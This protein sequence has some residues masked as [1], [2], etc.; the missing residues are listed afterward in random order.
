MWTS[1]PTPVTTSSI[2]LLKRIDRQADRH[3]EEPAADRAT[4]NSIGPTSGRAKDRAQRSNEAD[5]TP[6]PTETNAL[7]AA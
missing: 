6:T 1:A 2:I 4:V 5:D 7:S 3:V